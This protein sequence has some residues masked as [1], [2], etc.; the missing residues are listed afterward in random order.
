MNGLQKDGL[1]QNSVKF[2]EK[3]EH[4]QI[5]KKFTWSRGARTE[6]TSGSFQQ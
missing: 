2:T 4:E 3:L 5:M 6:T 1:L